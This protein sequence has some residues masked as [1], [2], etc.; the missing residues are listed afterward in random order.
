MCAGSFE[1]ARKKEMVFV[2]GDL[3]LASDHLVVEADLARH[4]VEHAQQLRLLADRQVGRQ[5]GRQG[6]RAS[7]KVSE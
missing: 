6:A 7:T 2:L 3:I 1:R 5:A 4:L